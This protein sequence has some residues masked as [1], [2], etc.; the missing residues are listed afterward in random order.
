MNK[1]TRLI[2]FIG[3]TLIALTSSAQASFS[4]NWG[5]SLDNGLYGYQQLGA[6][7]VSNGYSANQTAAENFAKTGYIGY[8]GST[9]DPFS[10]AGNQT[11]T[12]RIVSEASMF[13]NFN[14]LGY[15]SGAPGDNTQLLGGMQNGP[16]SFSSTDPFGFYI[17]TPQQNT[18]YSDRFANINNDPHAL[19]YQLQPNRYLIAWED[20]NLLSADRDYN[21]MYILVDTKDNNV[22]PEPMT[23]ALFSMGS[24]ALWFLKRR[25]V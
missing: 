20:V 6:W 4:V 15:Y 22:V 23:M 11:A 25:K 24:G 17:H 19:I 12:V 21:D 5:K 9:A 8:S 10:W 14:I 2:L 7:M 3:I 13:Q 1:L 18:W 16:V